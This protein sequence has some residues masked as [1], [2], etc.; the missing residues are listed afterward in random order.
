MSLIDDAKDR[1]FDRLMA[2][3]FFGTHEDLAVEVGINRV[4]LRK[5]L[6]VVRSPEHVAE[7][8]WTIPYGVRGSAANTWRI[9]DADEMR[10]DEVMQAANDRDRKSTRLNSS[11]TLESRMPSSA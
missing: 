3:P 8:S 9:I 5:V 4:M 10:N 7:H 11:H 2:E 1:V 6:E